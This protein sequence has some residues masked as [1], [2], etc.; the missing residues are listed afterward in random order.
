MASAVHVYWK[1]EDE[2]PDGEAVGPMI[3]QRDDGSLD[4]QDEWVTRS[5]AAAYAKEN[6][7][8]FHASNRAVALDDQ[9]QHDDERGHAQRRCAFEVNRAASVAIRAD[10]EHATARCS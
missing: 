4:E 8:E 5:V 2:E 3:I 9:R 6:G 1:W 7:L 10:S